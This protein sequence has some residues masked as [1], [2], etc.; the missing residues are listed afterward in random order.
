[1]SREQYEELV[2]YI[3]GYCNKN[4]IKPND[5]SS[6]MDELKLNVLEKYFDSVPDTYVLKKNGTVEK[7][8]QEKLYISIGAASDS[9]D[10]P[11]TSSDIHNIVVRAL[12]SLEKGRVNIIPTYLIRRRVLEAMKEL[13]FD[14]VYN[15]YRN[16]TIHTVE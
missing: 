3:Y 10:E 8:D 11:L 16:T 9:I 14:D 13:G 2:D 5:V 1:M 7:F 6:F 12:K 15:K 4:M